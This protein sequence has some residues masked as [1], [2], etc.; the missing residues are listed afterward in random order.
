MD[1]SHTTQG[2]ILTRSQ[3][4]AI[5][6]SIR[7]SHH[8]F[9]MPL[10]LEFRSFFHIPTSLIVETSSLRQELRAAGGCWV[11]NLT[12]AER[13]RTHELRVQTP[14]PYICLTTLSTTAN[15]P[16]LWCLP[17]DMLKMLLLIS[18]VEEWTI[19]MGTRTWNFFGE[20][21]TR[22]NFSQTFC[23]EPPAVHSIGKTDQSSNYRAVFNYPMEALLDCSVNAYAK[24]VEIWTT[25]V[26]FLIIRIILREIILTFYHMVRENTLPASTFE[27][28][29]FSAAKTCTWQRLFTYYHENGGPVYFKT[30]DKSKNHYPNYYWLTVKKIK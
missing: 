27:Y 21:L 2:R 19:W 18:F 3:W 16:L 5:R 6:S 20:F 11:R 13:I 1:G 15:F 29:W 28:E 25:S 24:S 26:L 10:F 30:L 22:N 14:W 7:K 12:N 9:I 8:F 17:L 4:S 23:E